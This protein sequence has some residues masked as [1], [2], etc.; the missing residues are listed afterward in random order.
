MEA[1]LNLS[2][3]EKK[4]VRGE[5]EQVVETAK[6]AI[7]GA[8]SQEV[9]DRAKETAIAH[10]A[11]IHPIGKEQ[12]LKEIQ[13]EKTA[14]I[15]AVEKSQKSFLLRKKLQLKRKLKMQQP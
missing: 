9:Y 5:I 14:T 3:A 13:E 8:D 2:E 6:K 12:F 7:E 1:N 15:E 11:K 4:A 10:L